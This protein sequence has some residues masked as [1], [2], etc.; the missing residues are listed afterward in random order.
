MVVSGPTSWTSDSSCANIPSGSSFFA[1]MKV[2]GEFAIYGGD[3]PHS[4]EKVWTTGTT[5]MAKK[6]F[7]SLS[8]DGVLGV[9]TS[10]FFGLG[11]NTLWTSGEPAEPS[12]AAAPSDSS[13]ATVAGAV[14]S[15]I[16]DITEPS[17]GIDFKVSNTF[18]SKLT[19]L[20]VGVRAKNLGVA[21]VNVYAVGLYVDKNKASKALSSYKTKSIDSGAHSIL[22]TP[23]FTKAMYLKFARGVGAQK[24]VDALAAVEGVDAD[25][26][27]SF[28]SQLLD[29][30]GGTIGKGETIALIWE[31]KDKLTV[32]VREKTAFSI[33][34]ANLPAAIY[35]LYLGDKPVSQPAKDAF[36]AG[37]QSIF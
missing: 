10:Y 9:H 20:G 18:V 14:T 35:K 22:M 2:N 4:S 36:G 6:V 28:S 31:A 37:I 15:G 26:V 25:V 13:T 11:G 32:Q 21:M 8:E 27:A 19:L 23:N 12:S 24:I 5:A 7:L 29:A 1:Q 16:T 17:T 34:D 30:I 3:G 33:T